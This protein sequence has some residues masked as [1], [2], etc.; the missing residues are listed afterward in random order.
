MAKLLE[1]DPEE[2]RQQLPQLHEH[3]ARFGDH[4]PD[5]LRSQME[6]LERRLEAAS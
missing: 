5:E 1:V 6:E 4:L 2:W 3:Y